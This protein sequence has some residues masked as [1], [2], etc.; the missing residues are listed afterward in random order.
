MAAMRGIAVMENHKAEAAR[1]G[2]KKKA[3]PLTNEEA[4]KYKAI[5]LAAAAADEEKN[6]NE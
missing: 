6:K 3:K 1:S 2:G 5:A 4:L